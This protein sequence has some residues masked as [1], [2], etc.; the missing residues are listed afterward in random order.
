[1]LYILR[2]RKCAFTAD[3]T[4]SISRR[5][6]F[7][8]HEFSR[9]ANLPRTTISLLDTKLVRS[10][11][12]GWRTTGPDIPTHSIIH[13]FIA[14][15]T[16]KL[17]AQKNQ[18]REGANRASAELCKEDLR[19]RRAR[20]KPSLSDSDPSDYASTLIEIPRERAPNLSAENASTAPSNFQRG[21]T[22]KPD[23]PGR[24]ALPLDYVSS[25]VG[26][27]ASAPSP[28]ATPTGAGSPASSS[29]S[30]RSNSCGS[31]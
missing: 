31:S 3:L 1:M 24:H 14:P 21:A 29:W 16:T 15:T 13:D 22:A 12:S 5:S 8:P 17:E 10:T 19:D 2:V 30:S 18:K 6:A 28:S 9:T 23:P 7:S 26:G 27:G 4:S 20:H 25:N 11:R